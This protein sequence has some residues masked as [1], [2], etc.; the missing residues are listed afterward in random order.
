MINIIKK[1]KSIIIDIVVIILSGLI[2]Y[3]CMTHT[4]SLSSNEKMM[5]AGFFA[6]VIIGYIYMRTGNVTP[7]R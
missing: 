1:Y 7:K 4:E 5:V 2:A 3:V 6:I